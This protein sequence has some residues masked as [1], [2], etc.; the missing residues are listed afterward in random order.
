VS[1]KETKI[2][3]SVYGI[4]QDKNVTT[5]YLLFIVEVQ[6]VPLLLTT[7]PLK[8][9]SKMFKSGSPNYALLNQTKTVS[10]FL[11]E[12]NWIVAKMTKFQEQLNMKWQKR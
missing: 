3:L 12:P 8:V 5:V 10:L 6:V 2:I 4:L 11:L 7:L 9:V 1:L